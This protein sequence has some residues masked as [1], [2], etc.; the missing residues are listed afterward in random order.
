MKL[1]CYIRQYLASQRGT[2]ICLYIANQ[3]F[4]EI[5]IF[6]TSSIQLLSDILLFD[7]FVVRI[8]SCFSIQR[9]FIKAAVITDK[10]AQI[11]QCCFI[12]LNS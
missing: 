8:L 7:K 4:V 3:N 5:F 6:V 12:Q 11:P 10:H 9:E 1:R 2:S